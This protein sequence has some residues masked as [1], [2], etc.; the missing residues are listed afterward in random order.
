MS[1]PKLI[2][3]YSPAPRSGKTT[4]ANYLTEYGFHT[5][6]FAAPLKRMMRVFLLSYGYVSDEIDFL[7]GDGKGE[8]LP[9]I[10][11]T[12]RHLLQTVGT[13]WGR[14]CVHPEV[15][16]MCW[17]TEAN[18]HLRNGFSVVVDDVRFPNEAELVRGLGGE[19]W[20]IHHPE[21]VRSTTHTSEGSLDDFP[22]FDRRLVNDGSLL[23]LYGR[24]KSI[25]LA[26]I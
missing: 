24:L 18:R 26:H 6:S 12:P 7:L 20:H 19:L 3:L 8:Q 25:P 15:W 21:A 9:G 13:E 16:L 10:R 1:S 14:E 22:H 11:T 4:V 17:K 2:G 5:V 23:D